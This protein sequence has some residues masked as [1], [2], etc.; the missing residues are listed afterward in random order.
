MNLKNKCSTANVDAH[1]I[2]DALRDEY[3]RL[4]FTMDDWHALYAD[5]EKHFNLIRDTAS[6]FFGPL[7]RMMLENIILQIT[8]MIETD[9]RDNK[10][11]SLHKLAPLVVDPVRLK[12]FKE[13]KKKAVLAAKICD[14]WRNKI[15]AHAELKLFVP[16]GGSKLEPIKWKDMQECRDA[17]WAVLKYTHD[18]FSPEVELV[19][20]STPGHHGASG[21]IEHLKQSQKFSELKIARHDDKFD[22]TKWEGWGDWF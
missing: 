12:A 2:F 19:R 9:N 7:R 15:I 6:G 5:S 22:F 4:H 3:I 20:C 11:L 8:R 10:L 16:T 14:D 17:I 18:S 13:L 1:K 21:L